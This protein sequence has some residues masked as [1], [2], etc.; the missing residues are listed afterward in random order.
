MGA[1]DI[2]HR[3]QHLTL[4]V[5][6]PCSK[7]KPVDWCFMLSSEEFP[8][9]CILEQNFGQLVLDSYLR[10]VLGRCASSAMV[11]LKR[12]QYDNVC[13]QAIK[14]ERLPYVGEDSAN[15]FGLRVTEIGFTLQCRLYSDTAG[16]EDSR[17][18]PYSNNNLAA[19]YETAHVVCIIQTHMLGLLAWVEQCFE[20]APL[21]L[22]KVEAKGEEHGSP[23]CCQRHLRNEKIH[24]VPDSDYSSD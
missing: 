10:A 15:I 17:A 23:Y 11:C 21:L 9:W 22:E 4:Q 16:F 19:C 13:K 14:I 18:H 7:L 5:A 6:R 24:F 20:L 2:A 8:S 12:H 3:H 1:D